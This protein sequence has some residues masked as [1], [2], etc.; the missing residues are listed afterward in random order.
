VEHPVAVEREAEDRAEPQADDVA[1]DVVGEHARE[2]ERVVRD[3]QA[4][5]GDEH[6]PHAHEHELGALAHDL[7]ALGGVEGP[8]AVADVV[9]GDRERGRDDLRDE[10]ALVDHRRL[11]HRRAQD[12][13]D[14]HVDDEPDE[15]DDAEA[16]EL[17]GEQAHGGSPGV[18][19]N[20]MVGEV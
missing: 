14:A 5:E 19:Q 18:R 10:R 20:G 15:A 11:E 1:R 2:P 7:R 3:P 17:R 13:E 16:R 6:A 9:R 12:V 4:R 8:V